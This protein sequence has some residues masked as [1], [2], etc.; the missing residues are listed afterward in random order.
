[1][2]SHTFPIKENDPQQWYWFE[3][4]FSQQELDKIYKD[5]ESVPFQRATTI[6]G[7]ESDGQVRRSNVKWIPYSEEW[8]WV[9]E[10]LIAMANEA[11]EQLWKFNLHTAPEMIQYTEYDAAELGHYDWHQDIGPGQA[12]ARKVSL[13]VQLSGTTEY[14]GGDLQ[15]WNGGNISSAE[16]TPRGAGNVVIFPSYMPHRVAP[17]TKGIRRSFVLW[18]GGGH[19]Q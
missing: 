17:V 10:K 4:G 7:S 9:Y 19:Y 12:S 13:T 15:I 16:S 18:V 6:G 8:S 11:N 2:M 14:E 3:K 1:M 5:L